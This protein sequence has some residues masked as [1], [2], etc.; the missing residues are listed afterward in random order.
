MNSQLKKIW[1]WFTLSPAMKAQRAWDEIVKNAAVH[2]SSTSGERRIFRVPV[3]KNL[4]DTDILEAFQ[5]EKAKEP[6]IDPITGDFNWK[7][8][9]ND[10][11]ADYFVPVRD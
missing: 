5:A 4:N 7:L 1:D 10:S 2:R 8:N 11:E 9:I 3:S 6:L